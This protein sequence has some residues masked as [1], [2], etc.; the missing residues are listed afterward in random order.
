MIE[1]NLNNINNEEI[2]D[3]EVAETTDKLADPSV[4]NS[5]SEALLKTITET[6]DKE[7]LEKL[8]QKF[9]INNTKKNAFRVN[10]LNNLLDQI[11]KQATERFVKNP[12][13]IS[14]KEL[15]DYMNAV[16]NQLEK[17]QK[18]VDGIKD[19][20]AVQVNNTQ[21][22]TVNINIGDT[23]DISLNR[24]SRDKITQFINSVLNSGKIVDSSEFSDYTIVEENNNEKE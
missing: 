24:E 6:S 2:K 17:S 15:L 4:L 5:D 14:N 8:Y 10:E 9:N 19:I 7:E 11:N 3:T 18:A 20:N 16:Q 13:E 12:D 23:E 22:N 1:N 21:N